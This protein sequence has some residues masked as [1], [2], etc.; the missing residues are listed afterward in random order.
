MVTQERD[1][2]SPSYPVTGGLRELVRTS[3]PFGKKFSFHVVLDLL[4]LLRN[5]LALNG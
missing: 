1:S 3:S 5:D 2:P 4:L